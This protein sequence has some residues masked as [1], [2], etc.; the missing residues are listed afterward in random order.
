MSEETKEPTRRSINS[1]LTI[2]ILFL[3]IGAALAS[4]VVYSFALKYPDALGLTN[5]ITQEE[6]DKKLLSEVGKIMD[7]P[8][9]E[10][11]T[12]TTVNEHDKTKTESI[13]TNAHNGDKV[14]AYLT[15]KRVILYRPSEN[16]IIDV[17][18]INGANPTSSPTSAPTP[19]T[20]TMKVFIFNG[21]N[22]V[23]ATKH[24]EAELLRLYTDVQILGRAS[25]TKTEYTDSILID[26]TGSRAED[27]TR[28]ATDLGITVGTLPEGEK[29]PE[30][31]DFLLLV[32]KNSVT[33]TP[34]A[35]PAQ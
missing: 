26:L 31:S 34:S 5:I 3:V 12:I 2:A 32:G 13:F 15:S 18:F 22:I 23:G 21:T 29:A 10:T 35:T 1:Y 33:P 16:K 24:F 20:K 6:V 25:A 14:I 9:D 19:I 17:G 8:A 27:A 28:I 7:L 30:G 11:P 4:A